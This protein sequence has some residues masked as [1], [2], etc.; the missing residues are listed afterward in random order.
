MGTGTGSKKLYTLGQKSLLLP[1]MKQV[2]FIL[3]FSALVSSCSFSPESLA[4]EYCNCRADIE[5]GKKSADDCKELTESHFLKLQDDQQALK[6]YTERVL[7][8][9]SSSQIRTE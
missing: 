2:L 8:C 4:K 5:A 6:T 7:D 9:T 1:Y 3:G